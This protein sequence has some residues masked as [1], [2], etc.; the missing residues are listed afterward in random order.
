MKDEIFLKYETEKIFQNSLNTLDEGFEDAFAYLASDV[1]HSR[2]RKTNCLERLNEEVR[3]CEK[4]IRIFSNEDSA[5]LLIFS[6]WAFVIQSSLIS[7]WIGS[8]LLNYTL[9]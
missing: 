7:M 1:I 3:R 8:H 2:L 9:E 4:V 6:Q 5:V